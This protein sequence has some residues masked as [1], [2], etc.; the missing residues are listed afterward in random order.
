M[1]DICNYCGDEIKPGGEPVRVYTGF[2][3]WAGPSLAFCSYEC[4]RVWH[5]GEG[6][7]G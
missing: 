3:D 1:A 5:D 7:P 6:G 4:V 2:T